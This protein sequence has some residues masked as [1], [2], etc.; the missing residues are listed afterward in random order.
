MLTRLGYE[1]ATSTAAATASTAASTLSPAELAA[2]RRALT[3]APVK[4]NQPFPKTFKVWRAVPGGV[5]VP[6]FWAAQT[7]PERVGAATRNDSPGLPAPRLA[8]FAASLRPELRQPE[9]AE[10]VLAALGGSSPGASG[11]GVLSLPTGFGKT[12]VALYVASRLAVKTL[13]LVHTEVLLKQWAQRVAQCLPQARVSLVRG[14]TLDLEGDVVVAMIQTLTARAYAPQTFAACGLLV[15]DECHHV[16]A[17]VFSQAMFG[18]A[19]PR[20]LGL[21]ATPHRKDGLT[22]LVHWFLGDMAFAVQRTDQANVRVS[23][24]DYVCPRYAQPPPVNRR[25]DL[26]FASTVRLL[27]EDEARTELVARCALRL[28]REGR[29]VL[30]LSQRRAHCAALAERLCALGADAA[31]F[32]GGAKEVPAARVLVATYSLASEGFDEPRL[33]ALVLATPMSDVHQA[34]GRVLRGGGAG[35]YPQIVDVRDRWGALLGMQAKRRAFYLRS[36][37]SLCRDDLGKDREDLGEA[38]RAPVECMLDDD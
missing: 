24:L 29:H 26:C 15:V 38:S 6:R 27:V 20:V 11:G 31:A 13:V 18:L 36:G 30:V 37:F 3:V 14:A 22:R 1:V 5:A 19:L 4:L 35:T 25:G 34:C 2:A 16:G 28:A 7:W 10:A 9:A 23:F 32:V 21:S 12:T 17:E 33:N 8:A